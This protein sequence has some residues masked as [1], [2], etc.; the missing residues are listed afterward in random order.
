M[1]VHKHFLFGVDG[2]EVSLQAVQLGLGLAEPGTRFTA[3]SV[4][5][6][7]EGDLGLVG[8]G[9]VQQQLRQP[10]EA[11]LARVADLFAAADL[12]VRTICA[13]GEPYVRLVELA[14][15]EGC[16]LIVV[17]A[18]GMG[19]LKQALLGSVARRVIGLSRQDVLIVPAN[20]HNN[21]QTILL[22]TDLSAASKPAENRALELAAAHNSA[23]AILSILE[24]PSCLFG[25]AGALGCTLPPDQNRSLAEI[26]R[27]A[28]G[29]GVKA[30][31]LTAAGDAPQIIC[32]TAA[33][34]GA[35]IIVLGSHGRSGLKRLLLGSTA[36]KVIGLAP[37]PVLVVKPPQ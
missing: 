37:C 35:G 6:V 3:I 36:E 8:I 27:A 26:Q 25:E 4:A 14:E 29:L 24:L 5:P 7:Y 10:C 33:Q 18:K 15:D 12:T 22:A 17:G 32:A 9:D 2:S 13:L 16:D 31:L 19:A 30:E 1:G 34:K 20:A 11:A 23:L 28:T 21:W